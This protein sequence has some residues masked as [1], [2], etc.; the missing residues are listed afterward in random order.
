MIEVCRLTKRHVDA[1]SK[2]MPR[3]LEQVKIF[4]L[5]VGHG[6]GT[7]DFVEAVGTIEEDDYTQMLKECGEYAQFKLGNLSKYFEI[8]VFPEHAQKLRREMPACFLKGVF[9]T[10]YEGYIILRKSL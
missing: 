1:T 5:T 2:N 8:E 3:E 6:I 4:S 10:L 9:E 7:V